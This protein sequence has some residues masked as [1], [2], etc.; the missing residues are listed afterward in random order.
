MFSLKLLPSYSVGMF[1]F[2]KKISSVTKM[3]LV[4]I[5]AMIL[6]SGSVAAKCKK[7][8]FSFEGVGDY[9]TNEIWCR[10]IENCQKT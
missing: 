8:H 2:Y 6:T 9:R 4:M 10:D 3:A 1:F 5:V 7:I